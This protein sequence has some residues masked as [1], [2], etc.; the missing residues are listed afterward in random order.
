MRA[1]I[2]IAAA[3][4]TLAACKNNDQVDNTQNVD[5]NL[6]AEN[7]VSNDVTAIDAVTGDAANMAAESDINDIG[8]ANVLTGETGNMS[9]PTKPAPA[10][11]RSRPSAAPDEP[12]A[13]T[14]ANTAGNSAE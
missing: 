1:L 6:T 12:E 7:I 13:S 3:A 11:K 8:A 4:L 9:S 14:P 2:L 10:P 5:E